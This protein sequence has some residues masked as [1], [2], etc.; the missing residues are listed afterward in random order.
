[1][2]TLLNKPWITLLALS[3]FCGLA[4]Y[5]WQGLEHGYSAKDRAQ[6]DNI[7]ER[8]LISSMT[9]K[10]KMEYLYAN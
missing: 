5:S 9:P 8:A 2:L 4:W 6:M 3:I 7:I 10:Q 1:M